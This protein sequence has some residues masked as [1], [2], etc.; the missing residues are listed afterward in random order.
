[1]ERTMSVEE[2]I[3]R[4]EEIYNRRRENIKEEN[5]G[6]ITVREKKDLKLFKKLI[7]QIITCLLIY[8]IFYLIVNNNYIFSNDFKNKAKEI[9]S[10]DINFQNLYQMVIEKYNSIFEKKEETEEKQETQNV[11]ENIGGA[12]EEQNIQETEEVIL[13]Q[14]EQD[15]KYIK[16]TVNFIKPVEG[17]I[18]SK[19][20]YRE[21]ASE[22]IPKNHTGI[23]IAAVTGT[24]IKS[25][26]EGTVILASSEGD[27]RQTF[28]NTNK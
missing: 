21:N 1:M 7:L 20:G 5:I 23:D 12:I 17:T 6:R 2:K 22:G 9:L 24:K 16:E 4:A 19:Y 11:Q 25:A 3:R 27:Y 26:T 18:S 15:V 8:C 14:E 10:Y 28:K 13:S